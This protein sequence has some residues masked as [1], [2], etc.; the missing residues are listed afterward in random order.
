MDDFS[1][2]VGG[3]LTM[4]QNIIFDIMPIDTTVNNP[5]YNPN[6]TYVP[7]SQRKEWIPVGMLGKIYV[8]DNGH[9]QVGHKCDCL[10]GIAV[11][12]NT[13]RVLARS[14]PNVVR[15]LFHL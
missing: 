10:N 2:F 1:Q 4:W 7:R 13:Y 5:S 3:V 8:R 6:R 9:V 15:I 14:S 11:P 12:G